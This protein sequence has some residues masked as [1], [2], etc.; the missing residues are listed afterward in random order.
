MKDLISD[1]S[2]LENKINHLHSQKQKLYRSYYQ[3][4]AQCKKE[5]H[6]LQRSEG[7]GVIKKDIPLYLAHAGYVV[8]NHYNPQI[9][10]INS[11][12]SD[13]YS[14]LEKLK[15]Q[16]NDEDQ[17]KHHAACQAKNAESYKEKM[18]ELRSR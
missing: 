16:K 11:Q 2:L 15:K 14:K 1:I 12:I 13:L 6:E 3:D 18:K 4:L 7:Y 9:E 17:L 10:I 5:A 8:E